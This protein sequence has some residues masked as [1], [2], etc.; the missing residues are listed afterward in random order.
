MCFWLHPPGL[1]LNQLHTI[2]VT[3]VVLQQSTDFRHLQGH[4]DRRF[5]KGLRDYLQSP[6]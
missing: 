1:G 3:V 2:M 5:P 4:T 6:H